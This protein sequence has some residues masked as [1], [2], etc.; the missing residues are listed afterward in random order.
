MKIVISEQQL[1]EI[2][3]GLYKE[4]Y[5]NYLLDKYSEGGLESLTNQ[6]KDDLRR[7]SN[8][9]QINRA[10]PGD[11][12]EPESPEY[13]DVEDE[14]PDEEGYAQP[15]EMANDQLKEMFFTLYPYEYKFTSEGSEWVGHV[16][17]EKEVLVVKSRQVTIEVYPFINDHDFKVEAPNGITYTS[18]V[19]TLPHNEAEMM[20]FIQSF[21][22]QLLP[23]L[24]SRLKGK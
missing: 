9:E 13:D 2:V 15:R 10:L 5:V 3:I 14:E 21:N 8:G 22:A 24:I 23:R 6:E 12:E 19:N 11:E 16:W 7:L 20:Q 18:R 17:W 1:Q 4:R